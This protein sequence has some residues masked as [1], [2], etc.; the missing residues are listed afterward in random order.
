MDS[1]SEDDS[2]RDRFPGNTV[3][4]NGPDC[5]HRTVKDLYSDDLRNN[6][7]TTG[8]ISEAGMPRVPT[9][10]KIIFCIVLMHGQAICH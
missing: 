6:R 9:D 1:R 7:D 8:G 5:R 2:R 3:G 10:F 4:R